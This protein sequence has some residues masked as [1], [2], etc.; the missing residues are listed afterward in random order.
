MT[1]RWNNGGVTMKFN[2]FKYRQWLIDRRSLDGVSA[3]LLLEQNEMAKHH[4][5]DWDWL[6]KQ[7]IIILK[8]WCDEEEV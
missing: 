5:M 7:G 8:E 1:E 6:W 3:D 2:V 4:G